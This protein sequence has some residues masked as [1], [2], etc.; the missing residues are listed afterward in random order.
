VSTLTVP[1]V[2]ARVVAGGRVGWYQTGASDPG[3]LAGAIRLAVA[4]SRAGDPPSY[5]VDFQ[6]GDEP[7][8]GPRELPVFDPAILHLDEATARALLNEHARPGERATLHWSQQRMVVVNSHGL[9]CRAKVT[10]V[11]VEV[12]CAADKGDGAAH[13][14]SA[15]PGSAFPGGGT[16]RASARSL[17][18]LDLPAVFAR[19]RGRHAEGFAEGEVLPSPDLRGVEAASQVLLVSAEA[20]G[21]L[22]WQLGLAGLSANAFYDTPHRTRLAD[23]LGKLLF[24]RQIRLVDDGTATH[25]LPFPFDYEGR[26]KAALEL[27]AAGVLVTPTV[28]ARL[29]A[30]MGLSPT[31]HRVGPLET[32]PAHLLLAPG[33]SS[34]EQMLAAA[35][36]GVSIDRLE[37]LEIYDPA[38]LRFRALTRGLRE[39][40]DGALGRPLADAVWEDSLD[41]IF[42]DVATLSAE[43]VTQA[44]ETGM[45]GGVTAPGLVLAPP[46]IRHG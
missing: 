4:G 40:R 35:D 33:E 42:R 27:I 18:A 15:F 34:A 23:W 43:T 30:E 16:A 11:T 9:K 6:S 31:P 13:P 32:R 28:D 21:Q 26:P 24:S 14:G 1:T 36:G 22:T 10:T 44:Q 12:G 25:G 45:P 20:V 38:R 8:L 19:A 17:E 5:R 2:V 7:V 41:R 3:E 37:R 46:G 29:G 39:V